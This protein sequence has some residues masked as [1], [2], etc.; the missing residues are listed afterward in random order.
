MHILLV[1]FSSLGDIVM[2]TS[3]ASFLKQVNPN[4]EISFLTLKSFS[5]ILEKHK[6]IDHVI[7][8]EKESGLKDFLKLKKTLNSI[9]RERKVDFLID[10]HGTTR[11]FLLK[12]MSFNIP[13]ISV[14]KRRI[15]RF[16]RINTKKVNLLK[17]QKSIQ[18]RYIDDFIKLICHDLTLKD[19]SRRNVSKFNL[20]LS[21]STPVNHEDFF[22]GFETY[23]VIAPVASFTN[24]RWPVEKFKKLIEMLVEDKKYDS[25]GLVILAGPNDNYCEPLSQIND[26]RVVYLQGKTTLA[27]SAGIIKKAQ[28][29]VG[30]DSGMGHIAESFGVPA[31][32]IFGPTHEDL[33][34]RPHLTRSRSLSVDLWCRPCSGTGKKDCFRKKQ[35]CFDLISEKT[36]KDNIGDI[37]L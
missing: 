8:Y 15:E 21:Y 24:K 35:F 6:D 11:S 10:L 23:I 34:F 14:D 36:V 9:D 17:R 25:F 4:I 28:L 31:L 12:L 7:S 22:V 20:P 1:R 32:T 33:G 27:Q 26:K 29:V 37:V 13:Y 19:I 30:N 16:L 3:F 18:L 5:S 2:Q